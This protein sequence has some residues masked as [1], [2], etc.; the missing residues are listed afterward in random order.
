[1]ELKLV[2]IKKDLLVDDGD[3]EITLQSTPAA[4]RELGM[5]SN[6]YAEFYICM[7]P[8]AIENMT[9]AQIEAAAI[10]EANKMRT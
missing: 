3:I 9:L 2:K 1:M 10:R 5:P 6:Q 4:S 8:Y 7:R